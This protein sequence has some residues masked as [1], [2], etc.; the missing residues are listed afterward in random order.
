MVYA[1]KKKGADKIA[2][3]GLLLV[4]LLLARLII[5]SKST[6]ALSKP[7]VLNYSGLSVS[8]PA[9]NGWKSEKRWIYH[10]NAFTLTAF[11]DSGSGSMA[12]VAR[13]RYLLAPTTAA[14]DTL[15]NEKAATIGGSIANQGQIPV[16]ISDYRFTNSSQSTGTLIVD[17]VHI[18]KPKGLFDTFYG[19]THLPNGRQ[20][21]IEV[22]QAGADTDLAKSVFNRVAESVKIRNS[23]ILD[24]GCEIVAAIKRKGLDSFFGSHFDKET[25]NGANF[26]LIKDARQRSIGFT[27][28]VLIAAPV[29][30]QNRETELYDF[31]LSAQ[32]IQ[33]ASFYYIRR[34]YNREQA[35][36]FQGVNNLD[37]F[38]WRSETSRIDAKS[39]AEIVLDKPA[40]MTVRKLGETV[41]DNSYHISSAA[42][43]DIFS[44]LTFRQILD[45]DYKEILVDIIEADGAILP[46]LISRIEKDTSA[47]E[48]FFSKAADR[49]KVTY[50]LKLELLDGRGFSEQVFFDNKKLIL[51]RLLRREVIYI[52]E[53]TDEDTI[54]REFPERADYILRKSKTL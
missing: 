49:E 1:I 16:D 22:Y 46:L 54:L 18:Q 13:C 42:I 2:F 27:M 3:L 51:K 36:L 37:E 47:I 20:L 14:V 24:A 32:T 48:Q 43:P 34:P 15:F 19:V 40:V 12:A 53:R 4:A 38:T 44:E 29:L 11:F 25:K 10:K 28:D 5:A 33:A 6:I 39:G 45:S 21:D 31:D 9:G 41:E 52:I 50:V 26:F 8:I 17:W 30:Q 35:T 23:Q 7:L